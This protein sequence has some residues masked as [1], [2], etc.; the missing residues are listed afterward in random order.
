M[1]HLLIRCLAIGASAFAL[2]WW[3]RDDGLLGAV[4]WLL[5]SAAG[6]AIGRALA[7]YA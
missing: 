4:A 3:I 2:A 1:K 5:C 6:Y 7:R